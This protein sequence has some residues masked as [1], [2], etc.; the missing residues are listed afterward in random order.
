MPPIAANP[1]TRLMET[2]AMGSVRTLGEWHPGDYEVIKPVLY[3]RAIRIHH[4]IQ[5]Q[6]HGFPQVS[7]Y[8]L[9]EYQEKF[10]ITAVDILVTILCQLLSFDYAV[11]MEGDEAESALLD[12][13]AKHLKFDTSQDWQMKRHTT[14][15]WILIMK[16]R[17]VVDVGGSENSLIIYTSRICLLTTKS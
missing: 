2:T 3:L 9:R 15:S 16:H 6:G 4:A 5:V 17:L 1:N 10:D 7:D 11:D 14:T 12:V 13:A 8:T